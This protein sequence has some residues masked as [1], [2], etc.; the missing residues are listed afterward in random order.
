[1]SADLPLAALVL[2]GGYG[3][4]LRPLTIG[5]S[6]PLV[7]FCNRPMVEYMLDALTQ[8]GVTKIVL[9]LSEIQSDLQIYIQQYQSR[10]P[11]VTIIPSVETVALGTAGP[12]ALAREHL[13]GH[14]FSC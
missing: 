2:V 10:H 1:M 5:H 12:I 8:A 9:A 13:S 14:R 4:R 6:K 7:E 3:T 11:T